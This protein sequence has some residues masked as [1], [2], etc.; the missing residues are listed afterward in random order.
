M[1]CWESI[2]SCL[3]LPW[4]FDNIRYREILI[5]TTTH[6]NVKFLKI[7][8]CASLYFAIEIRSAWLAAILL[9]TGLPPHSTV[10]LRLPDVKEGCVNSSCS[11]IR[12]QRKRTITCVFGGFRFTSLIKEII[13]IANKLVTSHPIS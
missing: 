8:R 3:T 4:T 5:S 12:Y 7:L 9:A 10:E 13:D 1:T 6:Y 11:H 2:A